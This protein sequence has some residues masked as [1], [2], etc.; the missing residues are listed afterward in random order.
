MAAPLSVH[1]PIDLNRWFEPL[2]RHCVDNG[3]RL[4]AHRLP[5]QFAW[6]AEAFA[7]YCLSRGH[8]LSCHR[9]DLHTGDMFTSSHCYLRPNHNTV[10]CEVCM[11]ENYLYRCIDS[12]SQSALLSQ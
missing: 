6:M 11:F 1:E 12:L 9:I 10:V 8:D 2:Y 4:V 7:R 5:D 3:V